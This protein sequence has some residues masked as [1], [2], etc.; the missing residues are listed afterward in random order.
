MTE[1]S[2]SLPGAMSVLWVPLGAALC[3]YAAPRAG[4]LLGCAQV[5]APMNF[6]GEALWEVSGL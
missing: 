1:L 2:W 5:V 3:Y 6:Q 4:S